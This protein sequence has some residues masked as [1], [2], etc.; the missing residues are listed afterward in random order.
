MDLIVRA[1]I[2]KLLKENM[3]EYLCDW[4]RQNF[5]NSKKIRKHTKIDK[6]NFI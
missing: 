4:V 2:I 5:L 1:T 6:V 3:E